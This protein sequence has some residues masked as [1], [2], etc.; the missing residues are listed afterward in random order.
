MEGMVTRGTSW[1]N[2]AA[3]DTNWKDCYYSCMMTQNLTPLN[4][5]EIFAYAYKKSVELGYTVNEKTEL[6]D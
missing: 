3:A 2:K 5:N 6:L 4:I 1:K